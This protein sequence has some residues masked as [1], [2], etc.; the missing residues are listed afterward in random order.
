MENYLFIF[1]EGLIP[2]LCER[3]MVQMHPVYLLFAV[4][5]CIALPYLFG[6]L[7]F[8]IIL[9]RRF[10]GEDIRTKGSGNAGMTNM[11]RTY[12]KGAAVLTLLGD[13][14][15]AVFASLVGFLL[16]GV[17]GAYLAG[18][19]CI[20]GH[21]F[22]VFYR[23]KGGK[24]VVTTAVMILMLN[25]I[26][27]LILFVIFAII[28]IGTRYISLG[29]IMCALLWPL[30]V[31]RI[32]GPG[33]NVLLTLGIA[34]LVVFM[35]RANIKRLYEGKESKVSLKKKKKEEKADE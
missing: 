4:I 29:S 11:L 3:Q 7:N 1:N 32:E 18:L 16:L 8:A 31:Y 10:Y 27:F 14:L 22:P 23:F 28:V 20:L 13:M 17:T 30:L 12:G 34:A 35:H 15:K 9:S 2:F 21:M 25:P 24:G 33:A 19:F 5:L 26:I 6:S